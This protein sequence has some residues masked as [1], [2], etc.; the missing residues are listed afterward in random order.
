MNTLGKQ[1]IRV[2]VGALFMGLLAGTASL[3]DGV[4]KKRLAYL[5]S[6]LRIP[7]WDIMARGI[8]NSAN[9]LGYE[10][11]VYSAENSAKRELELTAQVIRE[12]VDGI[13]VSPTNSSACVTILRLAKSAGIPVVISDIGTDGGEFVSYI[14][15]DNRDG[16]YKIGQVLAERMIELGWQDGRVGI[17]SI[18]QKRLNGQLRTAGFMQAMDEAG[19]KGADIKQQVTFSYQETYDFSKELIEAY[20]DLRAIWLQGSDRYQGALDAIA[21]SG[22]ADDILL[23]CFDAEPVFL[24]LIPKGVLVGAA[25]QQPFLMGEE[26]VRSLDRHLN[27]EAVQKNLQLPILAISAKNIDEKLPVIKRNVLG[28]EEK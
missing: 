13:I 17:V 23:I 4:S 25:M 14:S 18:P 16:A 19:I 7:F 9:E 12:K 11:T 27:G 6:D 8:Q 22:K 21:D 15:S 24:E 2:L 20:P 10:I 28:I 26:S 5:V 3:A 1:L